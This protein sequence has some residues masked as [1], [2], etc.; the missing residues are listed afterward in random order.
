MKMAGVF[1]QEGLT[2]LSGEP[3]FYASYYSAD[4]I[5]LKTL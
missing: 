3:E 2:F 4:L 5:Y 1:N